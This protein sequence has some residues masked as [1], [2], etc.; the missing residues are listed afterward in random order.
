MSAG[1]SWSEIFHHGFER[2]GADAADNL[3]GYEE[4]WDI[5]HLKTLRSIVEK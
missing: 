1:A 4:G 5:R 3:E 2:L